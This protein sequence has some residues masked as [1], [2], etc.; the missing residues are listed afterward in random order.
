MMLL[1]ACKTTNSKVTMIEFPKAGSEVATEL[2]EVCNPKEKCTYL[3]K[4]IKDLYIFKQVYNV[5]RKHNE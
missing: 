2:T 1:T 3:Y 4:W 5:Y